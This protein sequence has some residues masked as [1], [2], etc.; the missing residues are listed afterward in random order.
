MKY[1]TLWEMDMARF[2]ADP[3]ESGKIMMKLIQM[4]KQWQKDT[5]GS[6]WGAF[7]GE[8]RGYSVG[9]RTPEEIMQINMMYKP[10]VQFKVYQA[11]SIDEVEAGMKNLMQMPR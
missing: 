3:V 1:V 4:V 6:D 10:Y 5:P 7:L 2:P 9:A 8:N 11:M